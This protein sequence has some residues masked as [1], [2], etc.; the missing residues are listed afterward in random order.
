MTLCKRELN[1]QHSEVDNY[2]N[3]FFFWYLERKEVTIKT[4]GSYVSKKQGKEK[5]LSANAI[6]TLELEGT[7]NVE[8]IGE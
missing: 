5:K 4:K 7:V 8:S 3:V 6:W 1:S 2:P